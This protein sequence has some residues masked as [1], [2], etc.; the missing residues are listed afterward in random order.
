MKIIRAFIVLLAF[1]VSAF[2]QGGYR[3]VANPSVKT[4]SLTKGAVTAIF[5]KK[6]LKW[7]DG[8]TIVALDQ[9]GKSPVRASFSSAVLGKS[10]AAVKSYWN[11]QIFAGRDVPLVEKSSDDEVLA[12]VRSTP[13]AV[14]YVSDAA[15][16][17]GVKV[18]EVQ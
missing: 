1:S 17:S 13:G 5:M 18:I 16:T 12:V 2:A 14:G 7:E 4:V 10:T 9:A 3:L 15:D 11:Q 6:T 8:S